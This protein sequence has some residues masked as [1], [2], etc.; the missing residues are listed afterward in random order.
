MPRRHRLDASGLVSHVTARGVDGCPVYRSSRDR[1]DYL[2]IL[3]DVVE[4]FH[5]LVYAY[6]LM[7]NHVHLLV[8]TTWPTLSAGIQRLHG[9]YGQRFNRRHGRYGHL[10][11]GRFKS[12]PVE[13]DAHLLAT[14]RYVVLNPVA[15]ALCRHPG[16][17]PWSSYR[18][19]AG[20]PGAPTF[21]ALDRLLPLFGR[22]EE[23][24]RHRYR[25][26]VDEGLR[27]PPAY[28]PS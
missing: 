25:E 20:P 23:T 26:F 22:D 12:E 21:L 1:F 14:A 6:C 2:A 18:A 8:E 24:A 3:E 11:Q 7:G 17:W 9:I 10:Y 16:D 19:T 4:R 15:A 27:L 28:K 13:R 5:W